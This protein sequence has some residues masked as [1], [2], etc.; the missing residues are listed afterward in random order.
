MF[1]VPGSVR[2]L[3]FTKNGLFL[4]AGNDRGQL[5]VF[6]LIKG[7]AIDVIYTCQQRAIWSIDVSWE[8]NLIAIGTEVGSIELYNMKTVLKAEKRTVQT[9]PPAQSDQLL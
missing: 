4:L 9:E 1:T 3:K 6:D 7:A 2:S 8:D 5:I